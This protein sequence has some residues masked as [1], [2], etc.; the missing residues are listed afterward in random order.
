MLFLLYTCT[1]INLYFNDKIT[2][3]IKDRRLINVWNDCV[4]L[5]FCISAFKYNS[6]YPDIF[7]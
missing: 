1:E 4:T 2:C 6:E 7:V 3:Y 5:F